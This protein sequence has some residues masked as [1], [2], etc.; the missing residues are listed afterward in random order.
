MSKIFITEDDVKNMV[1][2]VLSRLNEDV[3]V[4]KLNDKSKTANITYKTGKAERGTK[5][6]YGDSLGTEKMDQLNSDTIIVPLKGG[7]NSYN[8]T[9]INGVAVMH[10]FKNYFDRKKTTISVSDADTDKKE[11]YQLKMDEREFN[12]FKKMFFEK[13]NKVIQYKLMEFGNV[14]FEKVS[15]YP[16]PSSS[17]FNSTM[18]KEMETMVFSG[19]KGGTQVINQDLFKKDLKNL[20]V[21]TDF[22]EHNKDYYNSPLYSDQPDGETHMNS[23]VTNSNKYRTM[24]SYIDIYVAYINRLVKEIMIKVNA[25]K[26]YAKTHYGTEFTNT[27]GERI[28]PLYQQLASC[29][30]AIYEKSKYWDDYAQQYRHQNKRSQLSPIKYAKTP[31]NEY[32]TKIV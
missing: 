1:K 24:S 14:K 5:M 23:V 7:I 28:A 10:Y 17:K 12:N 8:I 22:I 29:Y 6:V 20:E 32:N 11:D 4:N 2:S 18:A 27:I 16:V 13:V 19:V 21:D 26:Y 30:E 3:Y 31:V 9:S 15:I 25:D